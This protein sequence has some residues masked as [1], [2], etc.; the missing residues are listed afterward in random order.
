MEREETVGSKAQACLLEQGQNA[1]AKISN[2]WKEVVKA[3]LHAVNA[4]FFQGDELIDYLFWCAN[5]FYIPAKAESLLVRCVTTP[6]PG[7]CVAVVTAKG[8]LDRVISNGLGV[9]ERLAFGIAAHDDGIDDR[10]HLA[11]DPCRCGLDVGDMR[12]QCFERTFNVRATRARNK[13]DIRVTGRANA[14]PASE[15]VAFTSTGRPNSGF[16]VM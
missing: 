7:V 3:Q 4:G 10:A 2:L 1:L 13:D 8:A 5:D 14:M 6:A 12:G 16:G 9:V 15:P 11:A